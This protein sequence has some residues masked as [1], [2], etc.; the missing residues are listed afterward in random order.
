MVI[1]NCKK[2]WLVC[3]SFHDYVNEPNVDDF[4]QFDNGYGAEY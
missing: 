4:N 3:K 1:K 2:T